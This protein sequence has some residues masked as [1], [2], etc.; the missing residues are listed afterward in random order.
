MESLLQT[1]AE[2][3]K[4]A[5]PGAG[6]AS[7]TLVVDHRPTTAVFTGR[8]AL[9][10]DER[11]YQRGHG[12]C[13]HA[14]TTGE[15]VD[16]ADMQAE[17]RWRDYVLDAAERGVGSSLSVPL[18]SSESLSGALNIYAREPHTFDLQSRVVAGRFAPYAAVAVAN[19]NAYQ[20]ARTMADNLETALR[21]RAV[22]DQAKGILMERHKLTADQAFELL[23]QMSMRSN[24]KL[25]DVA[26]RLVLTGQLQ[27]P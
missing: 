2:L 4:A 1:V 27:R 6:E 25:R 9:D 24:T 19:M 8:L 21:S 3:T 17:T 13:L 23:A 20:S 14:A 15:L 18:L 22:I 12:P 10:C 16:I 11:Q 5:L 26:D 7:V